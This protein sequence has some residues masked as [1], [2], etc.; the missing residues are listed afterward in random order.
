MNLF[1]SGGPPRQWGTSS[2][3]GDLLVSW[4]TS[5][6]VGRSSSLIDHYLF[7][8]LQVIG[9]NDVSVPTHLY[10]IIVAENEGEPPLLG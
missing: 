1:V 10:K 9:D 7:F 3:V 5:S 6:S 8:L 4:G 2:S